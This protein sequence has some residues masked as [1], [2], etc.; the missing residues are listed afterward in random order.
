M[1]RLTAADLVAA[2]DFKKLLV[3]EWE[4][5]RKLEAETWTATGGG[6][7]YLAFADGEV[8]RAEIDS[9][10]LVEKFSVADC[11]ATA[12]SFYYDLVNSR[13]YVH[14]PAGDSPS[15][16]TGSDY[17][18]CVLAYFFLGLSNDG[19]ILKRHRELLQDG[20]LDLWTSATALKK[21]SKSI[22]GTAALDREATEV[23]DR[24]SAYSAKLSV[25]AAASEVYI[26]QLSDPLIRPGRGAVVR[27]KYKCVGASVLKIMVRDSGGNQWLKSDGTWQGTSSVISI[28]NSTSWAEYSLTFNA[29]ASYS[30]YFFIIIVND[31]GH[32]V[33][34]DNVELKRHYEPTFFLPYLGPGALPSIT[35]SL[36]SFNDPQEQISFG[37]VNIN[38]DGFFTQNFSRLLW[39]NKKMWIKIGVYGAAYDDLAPIFTGISRCPKL[40]IGRFMVDVSDARAEFKSVLPTKF[41]A[42][43]YPNCESAWK[44]KP[45]PI[46]LGDVSGYQPPEQ[47]TV[48]RVFRLSLTTIGGVSYP[49]QAVTGVFVGGT[50]VGEGTWWDHDLAAGTIQV[51]PDI[52]AAHAGPVT[53]NATGYWSAAQWVDWLYFVLWAMNVGS[54]DDINIKSFNT[55]RTNR[56]FSF[57]CKYEEQSG[58]DALIT[59]LKSSANFFFFI[60]PN[61]EC[62]VVVLESAVPADAMHFYDED[63]KSFELYDDVAQGYYSVTMKYRDPADPKAERTATAERPRAGWEHGLKNELTLDMLE[64]S[65]AEA[66]IVAGRYADILQRPLPMLKVSLPAQALFLEPGDKIYVSHKI[67]DSDG[68]VQ[69]VFSEQVFIIFGIEKNLDEARATVTAVKSFPELYWAKTS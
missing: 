12:S 57:R 53:A 65:G 36:G 40:E 28:P 24:Y 69:T 50:A 45:I 33:Y 29:H 19:V 41:D 2:P 62:M 34:V 39:N 11:D 68:A 7:Y 49:L 66:A 20:K 22:T 15:A 3:C 51:Y 59:Q 9:A 56:V 6:G 26:Y 46:L 21:W 31:D 16:L 37:Q 30:S 35:H 54:E 4:L 60:R 38:D 42:A 58:I 25:S 67:T 17:K 55:L 64:C 47:D 32:T 13:V 5:A 18:Y 1:A 27:L 48:N 52:H 23:Y 63:F 10:A 8:H 44:E 43:T 14:T 61:G